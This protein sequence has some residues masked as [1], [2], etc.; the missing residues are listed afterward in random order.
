MVA[1]AETFKAK[2]ARWILAYVGGL[3]SGRTFNLGGSASCAD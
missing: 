1:T 3:H 2:R